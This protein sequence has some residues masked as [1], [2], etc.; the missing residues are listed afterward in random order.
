MNAAWPRGLGMEPCANS[1]YPRPGS[2]KNASATTS[3]YESESEAESACVSLFHLL[4]AGTCRLDRNLMFNES[5][6][7]LWRAVEGSCHLDTSAW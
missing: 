2:L 1:V 5:N 7:C 3:P 6:M 4:V